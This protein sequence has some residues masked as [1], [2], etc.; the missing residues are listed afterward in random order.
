VALVSGSPLIASAVVG[1][2][3]GDCLHR[4]A[5]RNGDIRTEGNLKTRFALVG[6]S[7]QRND[8]G[9]LTMHDAGL[10]R[11]G[12]FGQGHILPGSNRRNL[13]V[14]VFSHFLS[15]FK[16][17]AGHITPPQNLSINTG[18]TIRVILGS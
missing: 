10:A 12:G 16:K 15:P 14:C 8:A 6:Q 1:E 3:G 4:A 2:W 9:T 7:T 17:T 13:G 18:L 5:G 11:N